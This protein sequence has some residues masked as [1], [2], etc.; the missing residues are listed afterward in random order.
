MNILEYENYQEKKV[1]TEADFPYN[2]YLCSI[3]LDFDRVPVHWHDYMEII[4]IKKGHG[5][6]T[7]DLKQYKVSGSTIVL[8]L[9]GQLHSIEQYDDLSMEYENI[10]FNINM[11]FARTEDTSVTEF[12]RPLLS[13]KITVPTVFTSVSNHYDDISACIDACDEICKTKPEGYELYIKGKLF[14]FFYVLSNRCRED[15]TTRSMKSLDKMKIIMKHVENHYMEKISIADIAEVAGFSESHFMRYFKETMGTSFI[16]YLREY[17]LTMAARLLLASDA[18][19]LSISEEV[20]FD[21]LSYFNRA[22]K[23]EYGVTPSQYRK[24]GE[25]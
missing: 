5:Y 4:Y 14:E 16:D 11:L 15:K 6:V 23:K 13:G 24:Q 8:I 22:F 20:G 2:T 10:F 9:P 19:I 21:N 25:E 12:L 1:H 3:P 18:S 7:V 17:R